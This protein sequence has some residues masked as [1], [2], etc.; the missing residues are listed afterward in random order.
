M[1]NSLYE[2]YKKTAAMVLVM[3]LGVGL[4]HS[5]EASANPCKTAYQQCVAAGGGASC[6]AVLKNCGAA[7]S[8]QDT[9]RAMNQA[10]AMGGGKGMP[11]IPEH[12]HMCTGDMSLEGETITLKKGVGIIASD[13]CRL[14]L[15]NVT[16]TAKHAIL[17]SGNAHVTIVDSTLTASKAA[18][19]INGNAQI[20]LLGKTLI[21]GGPHTFTSEKGSN[22]R[23]NAEKTVKLKGAMKLRGVQVVNKKYT[24]AQG[25]G[26]VVP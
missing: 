17:I 3:S 9:T 13:N 1:K 18:V 20:T 16:I 22:V 2:A 6:K 5:R 19:A 4:A 23:I 21:K 14:R 24:P 15:K 11:A 26:A 12:K 7:S 25:D 8:P 10:M